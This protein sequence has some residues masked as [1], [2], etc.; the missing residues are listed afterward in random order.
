MQNFRQR[1]RAIASSLFSSQRTQKFST[2]GPALDDYTSRIAA[3]RAIF[4]DQAIVHELPDIYHYW[5]NKYLRP[6]TETLGFSNPDQFFALFLERSFAETMSRPAKFVSVGCGNCDTEVRVARLL[7]DRG[8]SDFT[9]E[10]LDINADMLERGRAMAK[11]NGVATQILPMQGDFNRWRP[12]H[13]YDAVMANQSLHHVVELEHLFSAVSEAIVANGRF[14]TAD[15]IGRNGH[16]L[17]PEARALLDEFWAELPPKRR[18][19]VQLKRVE[20][21]FED[22][23]CSKEGFEGIRAQDILPLLIERFDFEFFFGFANIIDPFIGRSFGHHFDADSVEDR[24]FIDRVHAR[25][26]AEIIAGRIKP[27]HIMGVMRNKPFATHSYWENL[28]PAFC[29]RPPD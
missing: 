10:C 8:V 13:S 5:S 20:E 1:M 27:T 7:L 29:V 21:R 9:I 11:E 24:A 28:T 19:N 14:I 12:S 6:R 25:D 3:E 4:A 23:D 22:W 18:Y 15:I 17:W 16:M 2:T 26:D